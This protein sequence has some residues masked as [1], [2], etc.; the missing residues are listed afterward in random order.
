MAGHASH[1]YSPSYLNESRVGD[2]VAY[3]ATFLVLQILF[4]SLR[5]WSRW[6]GK[7]PWGLDDTFMVASAIFLTAAIITVLCRSTWLKDGNLR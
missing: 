5:F 2:I 7:V 1:S 6:L 4:L 3:S